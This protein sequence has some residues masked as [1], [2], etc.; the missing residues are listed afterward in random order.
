M[1]FN[2]EQATEILSRT[3]A[4]LN[5]L[6]NGLSSDWTTNNEGGDTWSPYD[7][8]GHL[9][10][11]ERTDWMPRLQIILASGEAE[12]FPPFDR[13]A[14]FEESKG[15]SLEELLAT[16]AE[17]RAQSLAELASLHLTAADFDK[18]GTH[19]A[20]GAVRLRELLATW[21]VHDFSHLSQ[22]SRTM[23]KQY[24]EAVGPWAAY[25][26]ILQSR[27]VAN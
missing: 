25:L 23:A 20:F 19:P 26:S 18:R 13:F 4:V 24:A 5:A 9:I 1:Q 2:L 7:V 12:P 22:L 21:V 16:F 14:M 27:D 11:A 15:R 3:P 10:H 8:V 17:L 6:L